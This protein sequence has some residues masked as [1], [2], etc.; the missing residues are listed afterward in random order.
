[1]PRLTLSNL[2]VALCL[3]AAVAG[4]QPGFDEATRLAALR[5]IFPG[6][7]ISLEPR[8]KID[9]SW[10]KQPELSGLLFLDAWQQKTCIV[11][12]ERQSTMRKVA[13]QTT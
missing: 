12:S 2:A 5:A 1:M 13:P 3:T 11:S 4:A 8:T 6:M 7:Q 9:D 10:P